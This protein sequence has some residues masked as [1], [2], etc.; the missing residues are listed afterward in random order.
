MTPNNPL[1]SHRFICTV[2]QMTVVREDQL[3]ALEPIEACDVRVVDP[4][5]VALTRE[6]LPSPAE[7]DRLA[8][9]FKVL[10]DANA[11]AD[12]V[13]GA[14]GGRVVRVRLGGDG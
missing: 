2:V 4:D 3:E 9:W 5:K 12:P 13:C 10:G 11:S 6:R 1:P 7:T 8:D 14:R